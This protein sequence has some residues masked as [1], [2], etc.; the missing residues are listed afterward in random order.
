MVQRKANELLDHHHG[1]DEVTFLA[2]LYILMVC[3]NWDD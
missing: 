3:K 2:L 1:R